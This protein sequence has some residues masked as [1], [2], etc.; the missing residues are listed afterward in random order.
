MKT[1]DEPISPD[2]WLLRRVH[3][4]SFLQP[5]GTGLKS[6]AFVPRD[7]RS[8][9]PDTTGISLYRAECVPRPESVLGAIQDESKRRKNGVVRVSVRDIHALGLRVV[10]E[11]DQNPDVRLRIAGHV[12]IPELSSGAYSDLGQKPRLKVVI[13]RLAEKAGERENVLILPTDGL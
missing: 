5:L 2:E 1:P 12:V 8:K 6:S 7:D 3:A 10:R 9:N 11:D 13:A 4:N